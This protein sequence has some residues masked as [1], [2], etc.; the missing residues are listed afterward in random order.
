MECPAF[1]KL[2]PSLYGS[3]VNDMAV[4][5]YNYC[6]G[7]TLVEDID[8]AVLGSPV[9]CLILDESTGI[10]NMKRHIIYCM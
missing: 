8:K 1:K 2:E 6:N 9:F 3:Q 4:S 10:S 5:A 7:T